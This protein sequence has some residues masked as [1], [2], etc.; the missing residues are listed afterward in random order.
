METTFGRPWRSSRPLSTPA[1][2]GGGICR[3]G[4]DGACIRRPCPVWGYRRGRGRRN[5]G[6]QERLVSRGH[7]RSDCAGALPRVPFIDLLKNGPWD[8][9]SPHRARKSMTVHDFVLIRCVGRVEQPVTLRSNDS[10]RAECR[11]TTT[12]APAVEGGDQTVPERAGRHQAGP[13]DARGRP[14]TSFNRLS[15]WVPS[16]WRH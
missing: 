14:V 15:Q 3:A 1:R 16:T 7:R 5:R 6:V 12:L 11:T 9:D 8:P 13:A 2:R 10:H 4:I